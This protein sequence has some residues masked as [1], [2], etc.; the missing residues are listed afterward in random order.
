MGC[1][2]HQFTYSTWALY[3]CGNCIFLHLGEHQPLQFLQAKIIWKTIKS[4]LLSILIK[5]FLLS[6]LRQQRFIEHLH[7]KKALWKLKTD[8]LPYD[9]LFFK[10]HVKDEQ[11]F[12]ESRVSFP[13]F[14][15]MINMQQSNYMLGTN[16]LQSIEHSP[17][18]LDFAEVCN[19]DLKGTN[20]NKSVLSVVR[21]HQDV[22]RRTSLA[23]P[24]GERLS[25][26]PIFQCWWHDQAHTDFWGCEKDS[27]YQM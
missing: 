8:M 10:L 27:K 13:A 1:I 26:F 6:V 22:F 24:L 2:I 9:S 25:W 7:N 23:F 11:N 21:K 17:S 5:Y 16:D 15:H 20:K 12:A 4:H 3:A 18:L 19:T 14:I